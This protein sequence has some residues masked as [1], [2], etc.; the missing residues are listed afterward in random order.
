MP[1]QF[2][3]ISRDF[4]A[5]QK[6]PG[7]D[8]VHG[9]NTFGDADD[10]RHTGIGSLHDGVGRAR[11]RNK[12]H[13]RVGAGL[14]HCVA[15]RV[16]DGPAF[17]HGATLAGSHTADNLGPVQSSILG[18]ERSLAAGQSLHDQSR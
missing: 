14:G 1:G 12:D 3:P 4:F 10:Q 5:F 2:G 8:H 16:E 11:R 18:V 17:V 6:L 9:G 13:G 15:H 7:L